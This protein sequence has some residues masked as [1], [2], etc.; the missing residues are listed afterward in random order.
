[1]DT[2]RNLLFAALAHRR[3][4]LTAD[5]LAQ[6]LNVWARRRHVP[7]AELLVEQGWLSPADRTNLER[8][9]AESGAVTPAG[10]ATVA[11][12]EVQRVLAALRDSLAGS[13]STEEPLD[14]AQGPTGSAVPTTP[15]GSASL[16][17]VQVAGRNRLME[18]IGRGGMGAVLRGRDPDLDRDIAVKVLLEE[19]KGQA[20]L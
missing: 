19:H 18:V 2:D 8:Q 10:Q 3:G 17:E 6:A 11:G 15:R 1:M 5:Q 9:L 7:L 14:E 4:L 13:V 16:M 12:E 20:E